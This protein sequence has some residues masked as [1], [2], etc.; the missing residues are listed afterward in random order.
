MS[1]QSTRRTLIFLALGAGLLLAAC[2]A[3]GT[4]GEAEGALPRRD[5]TSARDLEVGEG[6]DFCDRYP[7]PTLESFEPGPGNPLAL[8]PNEH[9]MGAEDPLVTMILYGD[10][11]CPGCDQLYEALKEMVDRRPDEVRFVFR[12]FPLTAQYPASHLA[13]EASEAAFTQGGN[14]A[15]WAMLDLLYERQSEWGALSEVSLREVLTGYAEELGLDTEMFAAELEDG[16]YVARIDFAQAAALEIGIQSAPTLFVN[17]LELDSPPPDPDALEAV[18][19]V[20]ILQMTYRE[21]P[22]MVIDPEKNYVAWIVTE[23]GTIAVDLFADLAPETVNNFAY[24]ACTGYYDD[25]T[26]HRVLPGFV[27]QT[28]DPTGSGFGGPA[29][30]IPDEYQGSGL[31]FDRAGLLSMAHTSQ[32]DSARGQF[33]ITLGPAEHLDGAFTIFGEVVDGMDVVES[34]SPRD[35]SQSFEVLPPGDRLETIIVREVD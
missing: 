1:K 9:V 31:R 35:Q 28:G 7:Q 24:L 25:I 15:F 29:Y 18:L 13:A 6:T 23:K 33:F 10:L 30:T 21:P 17:D 26:W 2:N 5:R 12:H 4:A 20:A 32:P 19:D 16:S 14:E 34:L 11:Q 22:P 8:L 3:Q 27:A